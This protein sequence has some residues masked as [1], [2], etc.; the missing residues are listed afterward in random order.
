VRVVGNVVI[1]MAAYFIPRCCACVHTF[2]VIVSCIF[3]SLLLVTVGIMYN[4]AGSSINV[5]VNI[6]FDS[7]NISFDA[8][9]VMYTNSTNIPPIVIMNRMHENQNLCMHTH[10]RSNKISRHSTEKVSNDIY[11]GIRHV[12]LAKN[13][14]WLPDDG[15]M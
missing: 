6:L 13:W 4:R 8:S 1:A 7:E 5:T 9:L 15:F 2:S 3:I 12:I 11:I 10:N 14:P